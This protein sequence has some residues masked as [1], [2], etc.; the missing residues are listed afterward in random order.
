VGEA[1]A[2]EFDDLR[3]ADAIEAAYRRALEMVD[4]DSLDEVDARDMEVENHRTER[5]LRL[6]RSPRPPRRGAS[7][8]G[9]SSR[10][11]CSS[12]GRH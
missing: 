2:A 12:A 10:P 5:L 4:A 7:C 1:F 11:C 8:R 9:R 3:T 6:K